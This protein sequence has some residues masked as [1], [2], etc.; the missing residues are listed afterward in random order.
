M[1]KQ[2]VFI[3]SRIHEVHEFR[4]AAVHAIEAADMEPLYFDSTDPQKRWPLK[5]GVVFPLKTV[6]CIPS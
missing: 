5:P 3:S 6:N 2:R 1:A 4:E